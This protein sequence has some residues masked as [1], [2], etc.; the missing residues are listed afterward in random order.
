[1]S[2]LDLQE[3]LQDANSD[4]PTN[5]ESTAT[6]SPSL[7]QYNTTDAFNTDN[8]A[9]TTN[10]ADASA[11]AN[12]AGSA[13][14]TDTTNIANT[15]NIADYYTD[16]FNMNIPANSTPSH[17]KQSSGSKNRPSLHTKHKL[18]LSDINRHAK[19]KGITYSNPTSRLTSNLSR[20]PDLTD[21]SPRTNSRYNFR[22][23]PN[24]QGTDP[25]LDKPPWKL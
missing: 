18:N 13:N 21:I 11:T 6:G 12:T 23:R 25:N 15:A 17:K 14:M 20:S 4:L 22:P 7:T 10:T 2:Q 1:M 9:D 16:T 8:I 5:Q 3:A 24:D 19:A